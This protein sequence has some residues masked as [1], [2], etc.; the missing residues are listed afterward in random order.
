MAVVG[1][2]DVR[3]VYLGSPREIW[4]FAKTHAGIDEVSFFRYFRDCE[5][6]FAIQIGEVRPYSSPRRLAESYGLRPPQS[7]LYLESQR[8]LGE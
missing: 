6:A 5:K 7:F 1:E 8:A 2:I 3:R 4:A